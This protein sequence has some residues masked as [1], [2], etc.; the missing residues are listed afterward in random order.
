MNGRQPVVFDSVPAAPSTGE[1][2]VKRSKSSACYNILTLDYHP[3]PEGQ[4]LQYKVRAWLLHDQAAWVHTG[5]G[6]T[7]GRRDTAQLRH[8][9]DQVFCL[10]LCWHPIQDLARAACRAC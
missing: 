3:S 2:G 9:S 5:Q 1:G 7:G 4:A 8:S 10:G 6:M